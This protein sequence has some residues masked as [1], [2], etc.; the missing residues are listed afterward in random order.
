M[1]A[2]LVVAVL[3]LVGLLDRLGF[4]LVDV[5]VV[6]GVSVA[7]GKLGLTLDPVPGL[8]RMPARLRASGAVGSR[9]LVVLVETGVKLD[10]ARKGEE[11]QMSG[12][13]VS[14][15]DRKRATYLVVSQPTCRKSEGAEISLGAEKNEGT[16]TR[17]TIS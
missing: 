1:D 5:A 4:V 16:D 9:R 2:A 10:P 7:L 3:A 6:V 8:E 12:E 11:E 15:F 14:L 13:S 17:R